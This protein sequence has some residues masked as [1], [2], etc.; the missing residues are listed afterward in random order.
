MAFGK[1]ILSTSIN[2]SPRVITLID[3]DTKSRISYNF[4]Y[5]VRERSIAIDD[6]HFGVYYDGI[7]T[8]ESFAGIY[9]YRREEKNKIATL[10]HFAIVG[11][12]QTVT[13]GV[14]Y[15][16]HSRRLVIVWS[17]MIEVW[18]ISDINSEF[19]VT[20]IS[21]ITLNNF[22]DNADLVQTGILYLLCSADYP[23]PSPLLV[24]GGILSLSVLMH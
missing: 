5:N 15:H 6:N 19:V 8:S 14:F 10:R 4:P 21:R 18:E 7:G 12:Y 11:N 22:I 2:R 13:V 16:K 3:I 9:I 20:F 23:T 1:F 24:N 17:G